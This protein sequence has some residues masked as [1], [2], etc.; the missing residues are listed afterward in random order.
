[1]EIFLFLETVPIHVSNIPR[2]TKTIRLTPSQMVISVTKK[3][4]KI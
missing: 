4:K 3:K 1:M 2:G